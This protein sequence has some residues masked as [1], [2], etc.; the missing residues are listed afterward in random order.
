MDDLPS[1]VFGAKDSRNPQSDG[2]NFGSL[3]NLCQVPLDFYEAGQA[4]SYVRRHGIE[5]KCLA[6]SVDS[7]CAFHHL[8]AILPPDSERA[9]WVTKA[10]VVPLGKQPFQGLRI[11]VYEIGK[12][13]M[14]CIDDSGEIV[15]HSHRN[16]SLGGR[17]KKCAM[18]LVAYTEERQLLSAA[19]CLTVTLG[20]Q[21]M[22]CN[23]LSAFL[24]RDARQ[25]DNGG[26]ARE[27]ASPASALVFDPRAV[28]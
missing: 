27:R 22:L 28:S 5:S 17:S 1:A 12:R 21:R 18:C 20:S 8:G 16:S 4:R 2:R 15:G 13:G 25:V 14:R 19:R 10:H 26:C 11:P 7:C 6:I 23:S 3:A 24:L 9:K